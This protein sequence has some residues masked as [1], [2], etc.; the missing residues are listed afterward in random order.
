[1]T[2]LLT[3]LAVGAAMLVGVG[4]AQ[5]EPLKLSPSQMDGVTAAGFFSVASARANAVALF[6]RVNV[7]KT[8]ASTFTAPGVAASESKAFSLSAG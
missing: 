3:G 6:G 5:A 1:M 2:K 4:A 7:A 8:S